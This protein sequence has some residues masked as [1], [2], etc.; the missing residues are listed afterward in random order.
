MKEGSRW[1]VRLVRL[2]N[3]LIDTASS[4]RAAQRHRAL[5]ER[6]ADARQMIKTRISDSRWTITTNRLIL[7]LRCVLLDGPS[8][9]PVCSRFMRTA[10]SVL[11]EHTSNA[12]KEWL[13]RCY[14]AEA[15][16][17]AT[18][19]HSARQLPCLPSTSTMSVSH[20]HRQPTPF[21]LTESHCSQ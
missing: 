20:L 8:H 16:P 11:E 13:S 19:T 3:S 9:C 10:A 21:S 17:P 5:S 6:Q 18:V 4:D 14:Y 2:P 15:H 12:V 1:D 7:D